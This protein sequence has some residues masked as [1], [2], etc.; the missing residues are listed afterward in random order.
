MLTSLR[1]AGLNLLS[2]WTAGSA[3][4]GHWTVAR[5]FIQIPYLVL[6][7]SWRVTLPTMARLRG[8]DVARL[9]H[10]RKTIRATAV[11]FG[12]VAAPAVAVAPWLIPGLLGPD[13]APAVEPIWL[14][15]AGL[16]IAGPI[17]T[18]ASAYL[19]LAD[20][21]GAVLWA[22]ALGSGAWFSVAII[23]SDL[24]LVS[25]G[26]GWLASSDVQTAVPIRARL[27]SGATVA[28]AERSTRALAA[29]R[30]SA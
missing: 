25:L 14:S 22:V 12:L 27:G 20:R 11:V 5:A 29:R 19:T 2:G 7:S 24:G 1:D 3:A 28:D 13:F 9:H 26:I 30:R 15:L 6:E 18:G 21:A 17:S 10:S 4:V 8:D 16:T 23:T